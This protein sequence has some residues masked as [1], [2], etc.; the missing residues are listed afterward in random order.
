MLDSSKVESGKMEVFAEE[1]AVADM[2]HD[3]AGTVQ[4]LMAKKNNR[5]V[6]EL[7]PDL[8]VMRSDLTKVRQ[9]LLNLL[10]N[11]ARICEQGT[12]TL[13][14]SRAGS[15]ADAMVRFVARDT[16][17]GMTPEQLARSVRASPR[18]TFRR[19]GVSAARGSACR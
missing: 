19:R 4:S 5:P 10:G 7:A 13:L 11:A 17:I 8:G 15:E 6:L 2:A 14:I 3:L 16:G 1:F 9:I 12:V 18:P